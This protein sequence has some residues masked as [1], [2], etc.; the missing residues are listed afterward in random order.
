MLTAV[1][2]FTTV[3]YR[4]ANDVIYTFNFTKTRIIYVAAFNNSFDIHI[5]FDRGHYFLFNCNPY[6]IFK[7]VNPRV[8]TIGNSD[9]FFTY[10]LLH[11][12]SIKFVRYSFLIPMIFVSFRLTGKQDT[13]HYTH[14]FLTI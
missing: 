14:L 13:S 7:T 6:G 3:A 5:H 1:S 12:K 4:V 9:P 2:F 8:H 10:L 11:L